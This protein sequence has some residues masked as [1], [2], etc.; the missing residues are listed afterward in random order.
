[1]TANY[2]WALGFEGGTLTEIAR[3]G[4]GGGSGA[5]ISATAHTGAYG[6]AL[7]QDAGA[8]AYWPLPY[9]K[10]EFYWSVWMHPSGTYDEDNRVFLQFRL[11]DGNTVGLRW[12]SAHRFDIVVGAAVVG[13]G[14]ISGI[15]NAWHLVEIHAYIHDTNGFVEFRVDGVY[16]SRYDG[17]TQAASSDQISYVRVAGGKSFGGWTYF[18]DFC[19][20][21]DDWAGD[22]RIDG[23]FP[24]AD[25]VAEWEPSTPAADH[26]TMVDER[27]AS[28]AD[29][30]RASGTAAL[31]QYE[32]EDWAGAGLLPVLVVVR[33][34]CKKEATDNTLVKFFVDDGVTDVTTT[35]TPLSTSFLPYAYVL[36]ETPSGGPWTDAILDGIVIGVESE[37]P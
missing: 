29:Y 16:D 24:N 4:S 32:F 25:S 23:L 36:P 20:A 28:D 34:R 21:E 15:S 11:D 1:M 31:D 10:N 30:V 2:V 6:I 19:V 7:Q 13:T 17:D 37:I 5:I 18:D 26:Y 33:S 3:G 12:R 35:G 14:T 8:W 22:I 27:P 9:T